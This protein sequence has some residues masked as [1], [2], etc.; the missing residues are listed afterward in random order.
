[1]DEK[2]VDTFL[3]CSNIGIKIILAKSYPII[4]N[5]KKIEDKQ[6]NNVTLS[7]IQLNN[8]NIVTLDPEN[9]TIRI[10]YKYSNTVNIEGFYLFKFEEFCRLDYTT[11]VQYMIDGRN[12]N[13]QIQIEY[14]TKNQ[15]REN[16][17]YPGINIST[18][19]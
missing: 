18:S 13:K 19:V 12:S 16:I 14:R 1:M 15:D 11:F 2:W 7:I 9:L 5:N 4:K 10:S 3:E 8:I 6:N 17:V